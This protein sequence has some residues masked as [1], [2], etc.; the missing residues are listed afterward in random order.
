MG[1]GWVEEVFWGDEEVGG[2]GSI[3]LVLLVWEGGFLVFGR[4]V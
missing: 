3:V 4:I 2:F 1:G